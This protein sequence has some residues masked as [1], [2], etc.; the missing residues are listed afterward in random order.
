MENDEDFLFTLVAGQEF[1]ELALLSDTKARTCTIRA[2]NNETKLIELNKEHFMRFV[3]ECK[4]ESVS[5]VMEFYDKCLLFRGISSRSKKVLASKS[6][7]VK[8]PANSVILKQDEMPYNVYFVFKGSITVVRRVS[9][10]D[11]SQ[12]N[13]T[14][15]FAQK[16][17]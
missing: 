9:K 11:M 8:Y 13:L 3:G 17:S 6:F 12:K 10:S 1:G 7:Y 15:I 2:A 5:K 14:G 4:T 16:Y